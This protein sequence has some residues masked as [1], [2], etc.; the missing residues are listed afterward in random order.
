[1]W[2]LNIQTLMSNFPC[3][4]Y[5]ALISFLIKYTNFSLLHKSWNSLLAAKAWLNNTSLCISFTTHTYKMSFIFNVS[6]VT[7][8]T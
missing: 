6:T 7:N 2:N 8:V 4:L 5:S 1:M 3:L